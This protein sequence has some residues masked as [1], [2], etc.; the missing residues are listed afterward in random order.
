ML[1]TS[2]KNKPL[3]SKGLRIVMSVLCVSSLL[4]CELLISSSP[5]GL[6]CKLTVEQFRPRLTFYLNAPFQYQFKVPLTKSSVCSDWSALIGL[7]RHHP[8]CFHITP[9]RGL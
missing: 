9:C 7:S 3:D 6:A 4:A 8:S 5:V 2:C 1:N